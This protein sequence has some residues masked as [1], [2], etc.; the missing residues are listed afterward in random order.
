MAEVGVKTKKHID[1]LIEDLVLAQIETYNKQELDKAAASI[2]S[3]TAI[4]QLEKHQKECLQSLKNSLH[5]V[6]SLNAI[7]ERIYSNQQISLNIF[8]NDSAELLEK[9]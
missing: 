1:K 6:A 2:S 7:L 4:K 3:I 5:R 9:K 8:L